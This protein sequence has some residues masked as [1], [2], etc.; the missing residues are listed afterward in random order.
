MS[1]IV[2]RTSFNSSTAILESTVSF[3]YRM[4]Y[5]WQIEFVS[6]FALGVRFFKRL[7]EWSR[8]ML[9]FDCCIIFL[10]ESVFIIVILINCLSERDAL[11][12][13]LLNSVLFWKKTILLAARTAIGVS[14]NKTNNNQSV[15][16]VESHERERALCYENCPL[17]GDLIF[18]RSRVMII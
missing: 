16:S 8:T 18:F 11:D 6:L 3:P 12:F 2:S 7:L 1:K 5:L 4:A 9:T 14:K 15:G 17:V 13:S 10:A